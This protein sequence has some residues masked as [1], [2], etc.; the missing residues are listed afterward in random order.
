MTTVS[1]MPKL[2][3]LPPQDDLANW[4][5]RVLDPYCSPVIQGVLA[6]LSERLDT[7]DGAEWPVATILHST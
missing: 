3:L 4:T 1:D 2:H 7:Y 5:T 6:S